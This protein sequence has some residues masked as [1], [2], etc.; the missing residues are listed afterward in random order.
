MM[1]P[2]K[3]TVT[4]ATPTPEISENGMDSGEFVF[5]RN[6]S[7]QND[8]LVNYSVSGSGAGRHGFCAARRRRAHFRRPKQRDGFSSAA[9]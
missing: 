7:V 9:G 2:R 4:V 1:R 8:L 5:T 3:P 6:G